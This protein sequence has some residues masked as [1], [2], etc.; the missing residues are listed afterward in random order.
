MRNW[1]KLA[2]PLLILFVGLVLVQAPV[3]SERDGE[4]PSAL[5]DFRM[6]PLEQ[7][8]KINR[9]LRDREG[10]G[11]TLTVM[12]WD[13]VGEGEHLI[14]TRPETN[15]SSSRARIPR[16]R[17]DSISW[18]HPGRPRGSC[19]SQ[20]DCEERTEEMCNE[21]GHNGVDEDS[22]A[23][24]TH[25]DGS[26]TCSGDCNSNGAVAFVTCNPS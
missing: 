13:G 10:P 3:A 25:V 15:L 5:V 1:M 6:A 2:V 18:R 17:F 14:I 19:D 4:A 8:K 26:K 23:V 22:V 24:T 16:G 21:A 12:T 11:E 20:E 9:H 7:V